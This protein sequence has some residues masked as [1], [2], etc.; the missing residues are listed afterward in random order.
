M[1]DEKS[2]EQTTQRR[3]EFS[4]A[5]EKKLQALMDRVGTNSASEIIRKALRL[6]EWAC[7]EVEAGKTIA[8]IDSEGKAEWINVHQ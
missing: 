6:Y 4:D 5:A 3:F 2:A 8:S 7:E 1:P